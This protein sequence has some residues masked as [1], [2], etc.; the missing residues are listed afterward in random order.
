MN[1][2]LFIG[3]A[4]LVHS[5]ALGGSPCTDAHLRKLE[6]QFEKGRWPEE[7]RGGC[8]LAYSISQC[9]AGRSDSLHRAWILTAIEQRKKFYRCN[10]WNDRIHQISRVGQWYFELDDFVQAEAWTS[11][12]TKVAGGEPE[13]YYHHGQALLALGRDAEA[14]KEFQVAREKRSD[15]QD[16][17]RLIAALSANGPRPATSDSMRFDD[18]LIQTLQGDMRTVLDSMDQLTALPIKQQQMR[19]TLHQ[20]FRTQNEAYDFHTNDTAVIAVM[21]IYQRYWADAMMGGDLKEHET[22]LGFAI[23]EHLK[24]HVPQLAGKS[25]EWFQQHWNEELDKHLKAH[26]CHAAIGKTGQFY[27]LLLHMKETEVRYPVTTP[28]DTL[29]VT[30]IFMDSVI[31]HGWEGY[32]TCDTYYPGGWATTE[33]L[34][35]AHD[36]YDLNSETF[37]VSYVKHEGKHFAD[38]K[39]FPKL[40]A[41]DL[42]YRAKLVELSAA[43][44]TTYELIRFFIQNSAYDELNSHAYANFCLIRDLSRTL[45]QKEREEDM[46]TWE[47]VPITELQRACVDL[48][49]KSTQ[50]LGSAGAKK[51]TR[52][53]K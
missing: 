28:E 30:V 22:G 5:L 49:K 42:E 41:P 37:A 40:E 44:T 51:V 3:W 24:A 48:L 10:N 32:A 31:S 43:Q 25:N 1:R 50:A 18:L 9:Y 46:A 11:K 12:W 23:G 35:C 13:A 19:A 21:R 34:Y 6:R 16:L 27:D 14:L 38:Y 47:Q 52:L 7:D 20:R 53:L 4:L 36:S 8:E 29:E 2:S 33:A 45:F 17:D 26:G 39:R 15:R